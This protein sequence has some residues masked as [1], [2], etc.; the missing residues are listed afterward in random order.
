MSWGKHS[1]D[2]NDQM[3]VATSEM[4][5]GGVELWMFC[6]FMYRNSW[7]TAKNDTKDD[8]DTEEQKQM[9]LQVRFVI[10]AQM[11]CSMVT[12]SCHS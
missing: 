8:S 1:G 11:K 9:G 6:L 10:S 12:T 7:A 4:K 5:E 3:T 2:Q